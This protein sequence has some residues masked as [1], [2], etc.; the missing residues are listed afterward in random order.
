[1]RLGGW[2]ARP[3]PCGSLAKSTTRT[4]SM[5]SRTRPETA[6]DALGEWTTNPPLSATTMLAAAAT[7]DRFYNGPGNVRSE[8]AGPSNDKT[9]KNGFIN[10]KLGNAQHGH[11]L[12]RKPVAGKA[13]QPPRMQRGDC[14]GV[15]L[16][17]S[18]AGCDGVADDV[19]A[20]G[21]EACKSNSA[22]GPSAEARRAR[23]K[24][25]PR[26]GGIHFVR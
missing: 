10:F 19:V 3:P 8:P 20:G 4:A 9:S 5:R 25:L 11:A 21:E 12:Q 16:Q 26:L 18:L 14:P 13:S 15:R 22:R 23:I 6:A 7:S 1:M 17:L 2:F 24:P